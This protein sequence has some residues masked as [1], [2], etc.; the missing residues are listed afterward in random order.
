[1]NSHL[2]CNNCKDF[3]L[4]TCNGELCPNKSVQM[5][6]IGGDKIFMITYEDQLKKL[7]RDNGLN[8][9]NVLTQIQEKIMRDM[10]VRGNNTPLFKKKVSSVL[11]QWKS[12]PEY[13]VLF[14]LPD[15]ELSFDYSDLIKCNTSVLDLGNQMKGLEELISSNSDKLYPRVLELQKDCREIDDNIK[16]CMGELDKVAEHYE[17][18]YSKILLDLSMK[19]KSFY[20]HQ[21]EE[22]E[23]LSRM[24]YHKNMREIPENIPEIFSNAV[25]LPNMITKETDYIREILSNL[26]SDVRSKH[27]VLA[28]LQ[29][30]IPERVQTVDP[31]TRIFRY[32]MDSSDDE[33]DGENDG[34]GGDI[35]DKSVTDVEPLTSEQVSDIDELLK[36]VSSDSVEIGDKSDGHIGKGEDTAEDEDDDGD[37]DDEDDEE[38]EKSLIDLAR[39]DGGGNYELSFF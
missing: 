29:G 21:D 14:S 23:R 38:E 30:N 10:L 25:F 36:D 5:R 16:S 32:F 19:P 4:M 11:G 15:E 35:G 3:I 28:D 39:Q 24:V 17:P 22:D 7:C 8:F 33:N 12:A 9:L 27:L 31:I 6:S 13:E 2:D 1:M 37:E 18:R 34:E 26:R 20:T